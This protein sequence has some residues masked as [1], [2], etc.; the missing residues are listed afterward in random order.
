MGSWLIPLVI[1]VLVAGAVIVVAPSLPQNAK[2]RTSSQQIGELKNIPLT[3]SRTVSGSP[4]S[5]N[6]DGWG[7]IASAAGAIMAEEAVPETQTNTRNRSLNTPLG[8]G[9]LVAA[10]LLGVI[11]L[12]FP[13]WHD[14]VTCSSD[15]AQLLV[16]RV[17]RQNYVLPHPVNEKTPYRVVNILTTDKNLAGVLTCDA[18]IETVNPNMSVRVIYKV[19]K[20]SDGRLHLTL[21]EARIAD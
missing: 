4:P 11:M 8:L 2:R 18:I 16:F 20:T 14:A 7:R 13:P 5:A 21:P 9:A 15:E 17:L 6:P 10:G 19:D 12:Y 3:A 1:G